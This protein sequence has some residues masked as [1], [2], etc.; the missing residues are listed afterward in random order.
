MRRKIME[1]GSFDFYITAF[2]LA[3]N[4]ALA[5]QAHDTTPSLREE[6]AKLL[7]LFPV[8]EGARSLERL[9]HTFRPR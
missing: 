3:T 9:R 6:G 8:D 1:K 2:E 5:L 7:A 4:I